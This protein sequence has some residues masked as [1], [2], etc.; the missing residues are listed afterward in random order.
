[1]K[2]SSL[3]NAS[4]DSD[5]EVFLDSVEQ[6]WFKRAHVGNFLEIENIRS[7]LNALEKCEMLPRQELSPIRRSATGWSGPTNQQNK[8]H[9]FL[10][11]FWS[12]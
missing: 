2:M 11:V 6:S 10:S 4:N 5:I 3:L 1:M 9:K 7:S 12:L 8:T